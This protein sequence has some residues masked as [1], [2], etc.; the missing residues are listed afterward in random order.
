MQP[1]VVCLVFSSVVLKLAERLRPSL[2]L[3]TSADVHKQS[4]ALGL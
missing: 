2:V 3:M 1:G 4:S